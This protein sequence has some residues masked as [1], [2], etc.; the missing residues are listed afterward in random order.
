MT[1]EI[2]SFE[3]HPIDYMETRPD[4][5]AKRYAGVINSKTYPELYHNYP[6]LYQTYSGLFQTY[7]KLFKT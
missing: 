1:V 7:P 4:T 6:E 5:Q 3:K 2:I